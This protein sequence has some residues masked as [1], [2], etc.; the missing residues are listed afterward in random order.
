[1]GYAL[2]TKGDTSTDVPRGSGAEMIPQHLHIQNKIWLE[3][4]KPQVRV[5][6]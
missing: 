4:L 6:V 5:S 1:M 3:R 2:F